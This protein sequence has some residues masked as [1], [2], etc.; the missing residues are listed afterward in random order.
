MDSRPKP[1]AMQDVCLSSSSRRRVERSKRKRVRR[2]ADSSRAADSRVA[3]DSHRAADSRVAADSHRAAEDSRVADSRV[4]EGRRVVRIPH[5]LPLLDDVRRVTFARIVTSNP[6]A[7][8]AR[9]RGRGV[10]ISIR[11]RSVRVLRVTTIWIAAAQP[12]GT[13]IVRVCVVAA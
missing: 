3:A 8:E 5:P 10:G 1:I 7:P 9:W 6:A 2:A 4:A 13:T 11:H 12:V